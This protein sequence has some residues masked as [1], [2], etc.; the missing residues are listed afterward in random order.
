MG[1]A[2]YS[3]YRP[4]DFSQLRG[5][6]HIQTTLKNSITSGSVSHAYLFSG[7]RGTGKTTTARLLCKSLLCTADLSLRPDGTCENCLDIAYSVHPDVIE[8]DAASRT[9]VDNIREEVISKLAYSP[10]RG[11]YRIFI[12]DEAHMLSKTALNAMLKTLEEPPAHI[13][14]IFC[15]TEKDKIIPTIRS[16]CQCFDFFKISNEEISANLANICQA[17][18]VDFEAEALEIIARRSE[19]GMR[20]AIAALE[21][22]I[23][24]SGGEKI[25]L[26]TTDKMLGSLDESDYSAIIKAIADRDL[27][28]CFEYL[29]NYISASSDLSQ[30]SKD[31]ASHLRNMY[32]CALTDKSGTQNQDVDIPIDRLEKALL[33]MGDLTQE[34]KYSANMQLSFE[35]AFIKMTSLAIDSSENDLVERIN[36]LEQQVLQLQSSLNAYKS[37]GQPAQSAVQPAAQAAQAVQAAHAVQGAAQPVQPAQ[38]AQPVQPV[39]PVQPTQ[40]AVQPAQAAQPAVQLPQAKKMPANFKVADLANAQTLSTFWENIVAYIRQSGSNL[41]SL[42]E[43]G[44]PTF[45]KSEEVVII[46]FSGASSFLRGLATSEAS[47]VL[48]SKAIMSTCSTVVRFGFDFGAE[49]AQVATQQTAQ[50]P[51]QSA[52]SAAAAKENPPQ[53]EAKFNSQPEYEYTVLENIDPPD[54]AEL[55][56]KKL[57]E[58]FGANTKFNR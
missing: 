7:P 33:I 40:P 13:V 15:T 4:K 53:A 6:E 26:E 5:Q 56:K 41:T 49:N 55:L 58:G 37:G 2:L 50:V 14:F 1:Q 19:G 52:A 57:I 25:T 23:A 10:S 36:L 46:A 29:Q 54:S 39:Q 48:I 24:Y 18:G 45:N 9:G 22:V 11:D 27:A 38:A 12:I 20:D 16:R 30:F 42:L 32:I 51:T 28:A 44:N 34:L 43:T 8:L 31:L 17:E 35:L 21:Q 47:L 3:K